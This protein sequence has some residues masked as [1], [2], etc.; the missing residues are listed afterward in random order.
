MQ[1]RGTADGLKMAGLTKSKKDQDSSEKNHL[2]LQ[3]NRPAC[4]HTGGGGRQQR[5]RVAL[6]NGQC[7]EEGKV[8]EI[9]AVVPWVL[10]AAPEI[11]PRWCATAAPKAHPHALLTEIRD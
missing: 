9:Y 2:I 6:G 8:G 5:L 3:N 4:R 7:A 11:W 1:D 10:A